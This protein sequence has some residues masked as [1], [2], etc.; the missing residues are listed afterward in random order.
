MV[1]LAIETVPVQR[2]FDIVLPYP[3]PAVRVPQTKVF[4]A[5]IVYELKK[6]EIRH[7][8]AGDAEFLQVNLM[9]GKLVIEAK[10]LA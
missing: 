2:R 4:V 6:S 5:A 8:P 3:V 9:P 1:P 7:Q 10:S